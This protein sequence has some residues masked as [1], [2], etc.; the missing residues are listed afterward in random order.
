MTRSKSQVFT[1][2]TTRRRLLA[3]TPLAVAGLVINASA[4]QPM[5]QIPSTAEDSK[6]TALHQ[7]VELKAPATRVYQIL[8]DSKQFTAFSGAPA[9]IRPEAGGTFSLFG[10]MI[11]GRNIELVP[12]VRIVQAWRPADWPAGLYS[13]VRFE[14]KDQGPNTTLVLDHSSFPAGGFTHLS[15]GWR[16]HYWGP[17]SKYLA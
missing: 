2:K 12:G 16:E 15:Q 5:A 3:A 11:G 14:L 13:L 17:L 1:G 9:E 6:K 4:Q 7:E 8:I 10:G